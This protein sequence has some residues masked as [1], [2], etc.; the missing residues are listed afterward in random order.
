MLYSGWVNLCKY[1]Q[2]DRLLIVWGGNF[3]YNS[4]WQFYMKHSVAVLRITQ[5]GSFTY[6]K[7]WQ[8]KE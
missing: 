1:K 6:N 2:H 5:V 8:F 7:G 4:D 3:T